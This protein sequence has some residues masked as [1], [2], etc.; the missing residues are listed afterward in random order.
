MK[1]AI[2]NKIV[3]ALAVIVMLNVPVYGK[4]VVTHRPSTISVDGNSLEVILQSGSNGLYLALDN[5]TAA[6]VIDFLNA[7]EYTD[8][9]PKGAGG[10]WGYRVRI[11]E[12]G[13]ERY[14]IIDGFRPEEYY[15]LKDADRK[16]FYDMLNVLFS[17]AKEAGLLGLRED[18]ARRLLAGER[19]R[20]LR[21]LIMN[22]IHGEAPIKV[23]MPGAA[24]L[25]GCLGCIY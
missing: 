5:N 15:R 2:I 9:Y 3:L 7:A 12:D 4:N 23:S 8:Y 18:D 25:A 11:Y 19:K 17:E 6:K 10:G 14:N 1:A 22:A 20:L 21:S 13:I 16:R 24:I